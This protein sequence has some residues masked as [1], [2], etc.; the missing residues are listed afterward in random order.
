MLWTKAVMIL[1]EQPAFEPSSGQPV[2]D[3]TSLAATHSR[4]ASACRY[5]TSAALPWKQLETLGLNDLQLNEG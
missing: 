2:E 1:W 3:T 5:A 4:S